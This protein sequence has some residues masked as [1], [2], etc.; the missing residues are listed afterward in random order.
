MFSRLILLNRWEHD[1]LAGSLLHGARAGHLRRVPPSGLQQRY[2]SS[3]RLAEKENDHDNDKDADKRSAGGVNGGG[4]SL[5]AVRHF[6]TSE[7]EAVIITAIISIQLFWRNL[8]S[9]GVA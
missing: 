1:E 2:K 4:G 7:D 8:D 9:Y 3:E 5:E 6:D